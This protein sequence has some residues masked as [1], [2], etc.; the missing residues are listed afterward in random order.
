MS[1]PEL[2]KQEKG[3]PLRAA[4]RSQRM[5]FRDALMDPS[6]SSGDDITLDLTTKSSS[7]TTSSSST[8]EKV[9]SDVKSEGGTGDGLRGKQHIS[10]LDRIMIRAVMQSSCGANMCRQPLRARTVVLLPNPLPHHTSQHSS[11]GIVLLAA[12]LPEPNLSSRKKICTTPIT[13]FLARR[14]FSGRGGGDV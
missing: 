14:H 7:T 9:V 13:R 11:P 6:G 10:V 5:N 8:T 2:R 4:H 3:L 12:P 1:L